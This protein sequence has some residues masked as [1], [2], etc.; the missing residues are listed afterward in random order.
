MRGDGSS[1]RP[2]SGMVNSA[3]RSP[4]P[5]L[6]YGV[7][8][9]CSS[10]GVGDASELP[11]QSYARRGTIHFP[12]APPRDTGRQIW[13]RATATRSRG[14]MI[15]SRAPRPRNVGRPCRV[16]A[17]DPSRSLR[18][19]ASDPGSGRTVAPIV[20]RNTPIQG[21]R[22]AIMTHSK[23]VMDVKWRPVQAASST[24]CTPSTIWSLA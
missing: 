20:G 3:D 21:G 14:A 24:R 19:G 23:A 22:A 2:R 4:H 5:Q 18:C 16:T 11:C 6:A 7:Q 8:S 1:L 15:L 12:R 17:L 10:G 13:R 9:E